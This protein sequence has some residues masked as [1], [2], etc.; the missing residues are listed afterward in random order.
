MVNLGDYF[1]ELGVLR[2]FDEGIKYAYFWTLGVFLPLLNSILLLL[3][4]RPTSEIV[5]SRFCAYLKTI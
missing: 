3:K 4:D 1:M 5:D 2:T